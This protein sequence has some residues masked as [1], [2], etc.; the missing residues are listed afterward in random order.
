M[1]VWPICFWSIW[2]IGAPA[3]MRLPA[4]STPMSFIVTPASDSA[5]IAASAARSTV[6]LSGCL[7][8]LVIWIPR[9][10]TSLV[11]MA[12]LSADGLEAEADGLGAVVVGA[13]RIRRQPHL[14]ADLDVLGVRGAVDDVGPHARAVAVDDPGHERRG[15]AGRRERDD[16]ERPQLPGGLDG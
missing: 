9:I 5:P 16:G 14:H 3:P 1:P 8:N 4:A 12:L 10:Q 6:S 15:D 11:A 7:P 13:D 2:P